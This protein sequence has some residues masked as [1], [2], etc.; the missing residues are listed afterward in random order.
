VSLDL[1]FEDAFRQ[2]CGV[3]RDRALKS[4]RYRE[5][6]AT[7]P[8][9]THTTRQEVAEMTYL[10]ELLADRAF[11]NL[12]KFYQEEALKWQA[13]APEMQ[14]IL[15]EM[16]MMEFTSGTW[17]KR[18]KSRQ[19]RAHRSVDSVLP[20][21]CGS[22][23][24]GKVQPNC[25]GLAQMMI[26]FARATGER[27]LLVDTVR[28]HDGGTLRRMY[29]TTEWLARHLDPYAQQSRAIE[30]ELHFVKMCRDDMLRIL[31]SLPEIQAHHALA[32]RHQSSWF[33]VDPY[34]NRQYPVVLNKRWDTVFQH[35]GERDP[36]RGVTLRSNNTDRHMKYLRQA[37]THVTDELD[38][39]CESNEAR[40]IEDLLCEVM[41]DLAMAKPLVTKQSL[42]K[43]YS[44]LK[45]ETITT[46]HLLKKIESLDEDKRSDL[47]EQAFN[48]LS[49]S[50]HYYQLA[51][52]RL[53]R[54][55][56]RQVIVAL[57]DIQDD[58]A[59]EHPV[60]EFHHSTYHLAVMTLNHRAGQLGLPA[61]DL[62]RF[63]SSQFILRDILAEVR[64]G[65]STK[66]QKILDSRLRNLAHKALPS[67]VMP[68]IQAHLPKKK[69]K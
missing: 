31:T 66:L 69:E 42:I 39:V 62:V 16:M 29:V 21:E 7:V 65:D 43:L 54:G 45:S 20:N 67:M 27:H 68:E 28:S 53:L 37:V 25:L 36:R 13:Q 59:T 17:A 8:H 2:G 60:V 34:M 32:L 46:E 26:G 41:S 58:P 51:L 30:K 56:M 49:T 44:Q 19:A 11:K 6:V 48:R 9:V 14:Q 47:I 35:L 50:P 4:E 63:S 1:L 64:D 38:R 3:S 55:V 18:L 5:L 10:G 22:W 12:P 61:G 24:R 15:L 57:Y 23:T 52:R 40:D 33:I